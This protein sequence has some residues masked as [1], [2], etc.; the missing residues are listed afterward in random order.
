[1]SKPEKQGPWVNGVILDDEIEIMQPNGIAFPIKRRVTA[2]EG[3]GKIQLLVES[4]CGIDVQS[5]FN[6]AE[7]ARMFR[8][9][10]EAY[11]DIAEAILI[12][13]VLAY[14]GYEEE[15]TGDE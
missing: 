2:V 4:P 15:G 12:A 14:P 6:I 5:E 11:L 3:S 8:E 1:M 10:A 7:M 9:L 13:G